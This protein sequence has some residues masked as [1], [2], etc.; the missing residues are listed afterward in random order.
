MTIKEHPQITNNHGDKIFGSSSSLNRSLVAVEPT[1]RLAASTSTTSTSLKSSNPSSATSTIDDH[2]HQTTSTLPNSRISSS[3]LST[4]GEPVKLSPRQLRL[5]HHSDPGHSSSTSAS[6]SSHPQEPHSAHQLGSFR[7]PISIV[8]SHPLVSPLPIGGGV[9]DRP[10][11]LPRPRSSVDFA[12]LLPNSSPRRT[13]GLT[14]VSTPPA[15]IERDHTP[16]VHTSH[17]ESGLTEDGFYHINQYIVEMGKWKREL[18]RRRA[19]DAQRRLERRAE[20][21]RR[22]AEEGINH[23][24]SED[25]SSDEEAYDQ[26]DIEDDEEEEATI[27]GRGSFGVVKKVFNT[28]DGQFYA[29]KIMSKSLLSKS[30][31]FGR[32]N[33]DEGNIDGLDG[34]RR[35]IAIMKRLDH[36]N[37]VRLIEVIFDESEEEDNVYLVMEYAENGPIMHV[38]LDDGEVE[39]EDGSV[40][41]VSEPLPVETARR[42]F[43]DMLV[44]LEYLHHQNIVHGDLKP[45]NILVA[46]DGR[47]MIG[48]FGVSTLCEN[49]SH[50]ISTTAGTRVFMAPECLKR[51]K[52]DGK[53][54]GFD[55]AQSDCWAAGV[56]LFYMLYGRLPWYSRSLPEIYRQ[57]C[58]DPLVFPT[59]LEFAHIP[60]QAQTL[61]R[62]M[63][64]KNPNTRATISKMLQCPWVSDWGAWTSD[65]HCVSLGFPSAAQYKSQPLV[66]AT[67]CSKEIQR[68]LC[69]GKI[70]VDRD[71]SPSTVTGVAG[72]D[73]QCPLFQRMKSR[74][75]SWKREMTRKCDAKKAAR[76]KKRATLQSMEVLK[77]EE[78]SKLASAKLKAARRATAAPDVYAA[79]SAV[80]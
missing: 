63:L 36:P 39:F 1:T 17:V 35:E 56:T 54:K 7:R 3:Q 33:S 43:R 75:N 4:M 76:A 41:I 14:E 74:I 62:I 31:S 10:P 42:Y 12:T 13:N 51:T 61:I 48:D 65:Q 40:N 58:E 8:S 46:G 26:E 32:L 22:E 24:A 38:D 73:T 37:I 21:A 72:S 49:D 71:I 29:M 30:R 34:V 64:D 19:A 66:E 25:D 55:G 11:S 52:L 67:I 9:L 45:E 78:A 59:G 79:I 47:A 60:V 70:Q 23:E 68:A 18:I 80:C 5:A 2:T 77:K 28:H 44:G 27:L 6:S 16:T 50:L 57:I 20:R 69:P 15:P 53:E